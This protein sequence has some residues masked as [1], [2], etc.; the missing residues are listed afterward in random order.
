[1][2]C[3]DGIVGA[4][5]RAVSTKPYQPPLE[6]IP[7]VHVL[8]SNMYASKGRH[9]RAVQVRKQMRRSKIVKDPG[10]SSIEINDV[11]HEFRAVPEQ[12]HRLM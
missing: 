4:A 8:M 12:R 5:G 10:C 9:G 1:M 11:V 3:R 7:V 6:T 2:I